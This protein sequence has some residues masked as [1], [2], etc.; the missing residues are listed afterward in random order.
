MDLSNAPDI[1]KITLNKIKNRYSHRRL[2][3]G[4]TVTYRDMTCAGYGWLLPGWIAEE[5]RG[6]SGKVYR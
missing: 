3:R 4:T 1:T 5:R 6:R 2:R